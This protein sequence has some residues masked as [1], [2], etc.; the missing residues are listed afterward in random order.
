[1]NPW[2]LRSLEEIRISRINQPHFHTPSPIFH[3]SFSKNFGAL[4]FKFYWK[5]WTQ[6]LLFDLFLLQKLEAFCHANRCH[7]PSYSLIQFDALL[8]RWNHVV[9]CFFKLQPSRKKKFHEMP[10]SSSRAIFFR[11]ITFLFEKFLLKGYSLASLE[12]CA[13]NKLSRKNRLV[14]RKVWRGAGDQS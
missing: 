10:S 9:A 1:M 11:R 14:P 3:Y 7:E 12:T 8:F 2:C 5:Y 6:T 13:I 4:Q